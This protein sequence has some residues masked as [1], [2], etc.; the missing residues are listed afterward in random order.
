M[1]NK[2]PGLH[3]VG[4]APYGYVYNPSNG[5]KVSFVDKDGHVYAGTVTNVDEN[6]ETGE[7]NLTV[8]QFDDGIGWL[9][10]SDENEE[11]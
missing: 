5:Q 7:I 6:E 11:Q 10:V 3:K 1:E 4:P 8:Q 2:T 9:V